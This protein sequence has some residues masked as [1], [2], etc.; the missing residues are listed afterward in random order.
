MSRFSVITIRA[1]LQMTMQC[2]IRQIFGA[3]LCDRRG[4][5]LAK[6]TNEFKFKDF[7]SPFGARATSCADP[8]GHCPAN[9][10]ITSA[11]GHCWTASLPPTT[12]WRTVDTTQTGIAKHLKTRG[13][14]RASLP[15]RTVRFQSPMTKPDTASATRSRTASLASRT[16][17]GSRPVTTGARR[18]S[19]RHAHWLPWS[20]SGYET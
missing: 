17:D 6:R 1:R 7:Y 20:C 8:V 15:E 9:G 4:P 3:D 2:S 19:C 12:C 16:G 14:R 10:A 18:S 11:P 13:S 5:E